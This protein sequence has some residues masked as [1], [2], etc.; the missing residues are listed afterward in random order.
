MYRYIQIGCIARS[1]VTLMTE[2]ALLCGISP[3]R[4]RMR[5]GH[6]KGT[7]KQSGQTQSYY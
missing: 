1:R 4:V 5:R 6:T 2:E 3:T 7:D